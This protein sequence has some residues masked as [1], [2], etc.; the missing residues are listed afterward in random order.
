MDQRRELGVQGVP[1]LGGERKSVLGEVGPG[2][3]L[4]QQRCFPTREGTPSLHQGLK[5]GV[6]EL[7]AHADLWLGGQEGRAVPLCLEPSQKGGHPDEVGPH[8]SDD[9]PASIPNPASQVVP[10]QWL[11]LFGFGEIPARLGATPC[12]RRDL[13]LCHCKTLGCR[14]ELLIALTR[15]LCGREQPLS[16][17]L[18][19]GCGEAARKWC[20]MRKLVSLSL[21]TS[22]S[23]ALPLRWKGRRECVVLGWGVLTYYTAF[24]QAG[25]SC[26]SAHRRGP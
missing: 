25:V 3:V 5:V 19:G 14:G 10:G 26:V 16:E 18:L 4:Y 6:L 15:V 11:P 24:L 8:K 7:P 12:L 13:P 9:L 2:A 1:L 17:D 23:W 20:S 21:G 22:A